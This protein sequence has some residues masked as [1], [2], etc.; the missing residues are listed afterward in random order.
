M[1]NCSPGLAINHLFRRS[2]LVV[3]TPTATKYPARQLRVPVSL[4]FWKLLWQP[5]GHQPEGCGRS[6]ALFGRSPKLQWSLG[7]ALSSGRWL[8]LLG[9]Q[10]LWAS[11]VF[12]GQAGPATRTNDKQDKCVCVWPT[13]CECDLT[14]G[15]HDADRCKLLRRQFRPM[16]PLRAPVHK[17][18]K[19]VRG[20]RK[21][22]EGKREGK[23][24][25]RRRKK[26]LCFRRKTVAQNGLEFCPQSSFGRAQ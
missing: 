25:Q 15:S 12:S 19:G 23:S 4:S 24:R 13:V 11:S 26:S 8:R 18:G 20:K 1:R 14:G 17:A 3:P 2:D 10:L 7:L 5:F 22:E 16:L 9:L 21:E 6:L